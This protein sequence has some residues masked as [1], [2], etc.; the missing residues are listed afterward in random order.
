MGEH[1]ARIEIAR[2]AAE[3][4]AFLANPTNLPRWQPMLRESFRESG[5]RIRVI[6]GGIGA[7]GIAEHVRF[8]VEQE[9]RRL[10]W[11]TATG[12]GCAGDVQ[13]H[14]VPDGA[15]VELHLRLGS[16]AE[17]KEAVQ[18]WTGD[19]SLGVA[20]ALQASLVAVK[21]LCEGPTT[22]VNLVSGGTQSNP[23]QAALRDSR[24]YGISGTQNPE[25][26]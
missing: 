17:R 5:D 24:A 13:V 14:E 22:G 26:S 9:G 2:P 18:H 15:A 6:G 8:V 21:E 19:P 3:V 10:C 4:F 11:A 12:V 1:H 25:T 7:G 16:R 23:G 20:E